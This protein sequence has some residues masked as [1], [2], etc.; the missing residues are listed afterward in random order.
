MANQAGGGDQWT[1]QVARDHSNQHNGHVFNNNINVNARNEDEERQTQLLNSLSFD[2]IDWRRLQIDLPAEKTLE[3][4]FS[5]SEPPTSYLDEEDNVQHPVSREADLGTPQWDNLAKWCQKD[6]S[7]YWVRGKLG[8]GKS[9]LMAHIVDDKRTKEHLQRWSEDRRVHILSY[10]FWRAGTGLQNRSTGLLRSILHQICSSSTIA[11]ESVHLI[12]G[13]EKRPWTIKRLTDALFQVINNN[14]ECFCFFIDGLDEYNDDCTDLLDLIFRLQALT[15]VKMCVSSRPEPIFNKRLRNCK[16]LKLESLNGLDIYRLAQQ[17]LRALGIDHCQEV[18]LAIEVA[19]RAEGVFLWAAIVVRSLVLGVAADDSTDMLFQRLAEKPKEVND[20]FSQMLSGIDKVH[21]ES[22]RFYV[23][24]MKVKEKLKRKWIEQ[25]DDRHPFEPL[26]TRDVST[27]AEAITAICHL[28]AA[29]TTD[30]LRSYTEL[31][32]HCGRTVNQIAAR[33][34]GLLE[35]RTR[36]NQEESATKLWSVASFKYAIPALQVAKG[37]GWETGVND[38]LGLVRQRVAVNDLQEIPSVLSYEDR[39]MEW[40][41]R[42]AFDFVQSAEG[43]ALL[44]IDDNTSH[45]YDSFLRGMLKYLVIA[46]S[47]SGPANH[48]LTQT[49]LKDVIFVASIT[50]HDNK[51]LLEKF[52]HEL[53]NLVACMHHEEFEWL[54][55]LEIYRRI[56]GLSVGE[57]AF[58]HSAIAVAGY[59]TPYLTWTPLADVITDA[60]GSRTVSRAGYGLLS[61]LSTYWLRAIWDI[62]ENAMQPGRASYH[63]E[64]MLRSCLEDVRQVSARSSSTAT[65]LTLTRWIFAG[66]GV[67]PMPSYSYLWPSAELP[68]ASSSEHAL[69]AYHTANVCLRVLL[70]PDVLKGANKQQIVQLVRDINDIVQFESDIVAYP[71][72]YP[73]ERALQ[74]WPQFRM[75]IQVSLQLVQRFCAATGPDLA[76][77][78]ALRSYGGIRILCFP[79]IMSLLRWS[80]EPQPNEPDANHDLKS[81]NG[82]QPES[83]SIPFTPRN[84]LATVLANFNFETLNDV[85]EVTIAS[86]SPHLRLIPGV[87][88]PC[89]VVTPTSSAMRKLFDFVAKYTIDKDHNRVDYWHSLL[90]VLSSLIDDIMSNESLCSTDRILARACVVSEC[91]NIRNYVLPRF[92]PYELVK[93]RPRKHRLPA[94]IGHGRQR[95]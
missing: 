77:W 10:F 79:R 65:R 36:S 90:D 80:S 53:R 37:K 18:D 41:H 67:A 7:I 85:G 42:S 71:C 60:L 45:T 21:Q 76:Q 29:Q 69:A 12:A 72:T 51:N 19:R 33:S 78:D 2:E 82:L 91:H 70:Q 4:A 26:A 15:N 73:R 47:R 32:Q 81:E 23:S 9:T 93:E 16:Q 84:D 38:L 48:S 44:S 56:D 66:L 88:V 92:V 27:A 43:S 25:E 55:T 30:G 61:P 86:A 87:T 5:G 64:T 3:W 50:Y 75:S 14:E 40:C 46:P 13:E 54:E 17:S 58:W 95:H 1:D 39:H 62:L 11:M 22:L 59:T 89:I 74:F 8:S 6:D 24:L 28:T 49:R 52:L 34:A 20:L 35:V 83:L 31:E 68:E 94:I 57:A 63:L